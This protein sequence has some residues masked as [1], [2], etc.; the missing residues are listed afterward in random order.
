MKKTALNNFKVSKSRGVTLIE[1]LISITLL[2]LIAFFIALSIPTSVNMSQS[3]NQMESG[4]LLAQKYIE[5][6]KSQMEND[7]TFFD[8]SLIEGTE[9]PLNTTGYT[10]SGKYTITT[11]IAY[12]KYADID[13][14]NSPVLA[15]FQITVS[16]VNSDTEEQ[17]VSIT[18]YLRKDRTFKDS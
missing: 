6:V 12:I 9:P 4:T 1:I 11:E 10:K 8:T 3:T 16:P 5:D 13:G 17:D 2:G 7:P 14:V 15:S 18:T